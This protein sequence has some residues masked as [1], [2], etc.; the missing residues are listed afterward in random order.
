MKAMVMESLGV[1]NL[2][3]KELPDPRP[4]PGQVLVRLRAASLN[5]RDVLALRGGYGSRQKQAG[6]IPLSDGAGEVVQAGPGVRRFKAG[7]RVVNTFFPGWLA[8]P[9]DERFLQQD[10]GG[11]EDGV[12]CELRV[13]SEEALLPI[14]RGMSFVQAAT[15]PCAAVT[16]WNAVR[17]QAETGPEHV[18]LTQGSGGVAIFALQFARAAGARVIAISSSAAKLERLQALG[19]AAGINYRED[20]EWGKTARKLTAGQG[21]DLVVET[22]GA[23]T[24]KQSI[25]AT[26][27][28]GMI[29]MIGMVGGATTEVNLPIVAM[30]SL[31]IHGVAV[32]SRQHLQQVLAACETN[33]IEPVVDHVAPLAE[34]PQAIRQLEG[35]TH[36][37][38]VCVEI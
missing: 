32:G 25:R 12:A 15:L 24:L 19:A 37:G 11:M 22:A 4:G 2:R 18:V 27:L 5:F 14:P 1:E 6:L 7:D 8:G 30:G 33:R 23:A 16:A 36:F 38:K 21:V 29:A 3:L 9:P 17:A 28:G 20:A 26:R 31:R 13:F 35:G 10:L 34:L